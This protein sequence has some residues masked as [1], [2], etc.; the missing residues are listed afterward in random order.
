MSTKH[1]PIVVISSAVER[2]HG[3]AVISSAVERSPKA[4]Q[5][6]HSEGLKNPKN[7][8]ERLSPKAKQRSAI[9]SVLDG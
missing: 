9:K 2:A 7:L 8:L 5:H 6:C 3:F 1:T 4:K